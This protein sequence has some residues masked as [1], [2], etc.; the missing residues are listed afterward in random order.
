M[1]IAGRKPKRN[2]LW[3][4]IISKVAHSQGPWQGPTSPHHEDHSTG[5]LEHLHDMA[6][7]F[8]QSE[9]SKGEPAGS[10]HIFCDLVSKV[11]LYHF[12]NTWCSF[13]CWCEN[14]TGLVYLEAGPLEAILEAGSHT[15]L[16]QSQWT[17]VGA[18]LIFHE[19][20]SP[21][22]PRPILLL[23]PWLSLFC[24]WLL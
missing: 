4:H 9:S 3:N 23:L 15:F 24:L 22:F 12:S 14:R 8:P 2:I 6:A 18:S 11:T 1:D 13:L 19:A 5:L 7:I 16:S 10:H 20:G 17:S 21:P